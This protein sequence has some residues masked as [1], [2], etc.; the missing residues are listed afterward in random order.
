LAAGVISN[1]HFFFIASLFKLTSQEL[2]IFTILFAKSLIAL[3]ERFI[4]DSKVKKS[5]YKVPE[6]F[7]ED[8]RFFL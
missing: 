7:P 5:G 1:I 4:Y 2:T 3:I 8:W 6:V